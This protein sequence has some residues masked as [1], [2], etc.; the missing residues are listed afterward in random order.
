MVR[1]VAACCVVRVHVA[2][3]GRVD[4][5]VRRVV[6]LASGAAAVTN[7]RRGRSS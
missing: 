5:M 2:Y 3:A 1:N 6:A 4:S 7:S